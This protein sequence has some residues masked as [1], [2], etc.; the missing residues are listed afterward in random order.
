MALPCRQSTARMPGTWTDRNCRQVLRVVQ[1]E[2]SGVIGG[3]YVL[4]LKSPAPRGPGGVGG[5][6]VAGML[7]LSR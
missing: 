6:C 3:E 2:H 1:G 5:Y 7:S 4:M